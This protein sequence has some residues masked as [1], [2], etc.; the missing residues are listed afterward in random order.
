MN[1]A[2]SHSVLKQKLTTQGPKGSHALHL[3]VVWELPSRSLQDLQVQ[4]EHATSSL[5]HPSSVKSPGEM[6]L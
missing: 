1:P 3:S 4:S 2:Y 5:Q 6:D